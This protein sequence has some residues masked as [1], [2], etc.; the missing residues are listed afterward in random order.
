M[1]FYRHL[2]PFKAISFDLDDTLYNNTPIMMATD[3]KMVAYFEEKLPAS[4]KLYDYHFWFEFRQQALIKQPELIHDV[5]ALRLQSYAYGIK[6]LGFDDRES[7]SMA[8]SALTYFVAERSNFDVPDHIHSLLAQLKKQW[9]L[10]AISN[11]NVDT[12][13]I[14]IAPYF[15]AIFHA[16]NGLKQKPDA[17]MFRRACKQFNLKPNELLHVGDCGVNDVLGAHNF[18][19]QT[20]WVSTYNVGKPLKVLPTVALSD[21]VDLQRLI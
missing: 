19:C 7:L 9:K 16:G 6:S 21:V 3:E 12:R 17:D 13:S 11:G 4:Q 8:K 15:D 2:L 14:G 20:V 5:G 10:I 1:Q 18:G